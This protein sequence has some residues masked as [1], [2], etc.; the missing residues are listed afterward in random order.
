MPSKWTNQLSDAQLNMLLIVAGRPRFQLVHDRCKKGIVVP[1]ANEGRTVKALVDRGLVRW[2]WA[3]KDNVPSNGVT[4]TKEGAE[5]LV[6]PGEVTWPEKPVTLRVNLPGRANVEVLRSDYVK[7]KT[8]QLQEFGY[9][10][11]TRDHVDAQI[12]ALLEGRK[13]LD[14]GLTVIGKMMEHEVIVP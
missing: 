10:D 8:K 11:L 5:T 9:D 13:K 14:Q 2:V 1:F 3:Q 12:T 6:P 4:L 7:A